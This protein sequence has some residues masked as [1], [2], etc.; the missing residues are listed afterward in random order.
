MAQVEGSW[1]AG[2]RPEAGCSPDGV[3][4]Q[5]RV[6]EK[7]MMRVR[8]QSAEVAGDLASDAALQPT[9]G[10]DGGEGG[11][12][13]PL[14]DL[15][16]LTRTGLDLLSLS[17][18][19]EIIDYAGR[20]LA[21]RLGDCITIV[22]TSTAGGR[23]LSIRGIFGINKRLLVRAVDLVGDR[24]RDRSCPID[25][26]FESVYRDRRLYRHEAGLVDFSR[27]V[28]PKPV[29]RAL[30]QLLGV[31][32]VYTMGLVGEERVLGNIHLLGLKADL[33]ESPETVEVFAHQVA[34][35]L[36]RAAAHK[37]LRESEAR[38]RG[39]FEHA[40]SGF[41]LH[42]VILDDQGRSVDY[43]FREVNAAFEEMTGLKGEEIV[44]RRA[45]EVL[46][47]IEDEIFIDV[48][49]RVALTGEP[50]HLE[51]YVDALDRYQEITAY[52]PAEGQFVTLIS[53]VTETRQRE[54]AERRLAER[55]TA[56]LRA[57]D[58][59]WWEMELPSGEVAFDDMKAAMLGYPPEC[60]ETYHDFVEL[61]HPEDRERAMRAMRDHLEGRTENYEVQYRIETRDGEL[62][63][64][65]DVGG[66][67]SRDEGTGT[68]RVVGIVEDITERRKAQRALAR[69]ER[70]L[71]EIFDA[72]PIAIEIYDGDGRLVEANPACLELFG[73]QRLEDV[74]G[75]DLFS[76]PNL[77][78]DARASLR[79]GAM[80]RYE[81]EFDFGR[82][83]D[84][85]HYATSKQGRMSIDVRI[86]PLRA[87]T[88]DRPEAYLAQAQNVTERKE[89]E[90]E[91]RMSKQRFEL[92]LHGA[93]LGTWDWEV[94]TGAVQFNER[95]AGMMGYRLE[96]LEPNLDT[97]ERLVHP[98]DLVLAWERLQAHLEGEHPLY[99]AE[100]RM[101]HRSGEWRWILDRGKVIERDERGRPLRA[102]GTHLDITERR[103]IERRLREEERMAAL[104]Q[105]AAGV[106]H[107]FR[108][109]L[110]PI[111][112]Y[113]EMALDRA[114]LPAS[115]RPH[116][117]ATL[118]ESRGMADLVQQIL[119]FTSR[120]MI[121]R[122]R[123]D[124]AQLVED[125]ADSLGDD[126]PPE[127]KMAVR[128]TVDTHTI[129]ADAA[130]IR[131]AV[132][133][134]VLNARD[135]MPDGGDLTLEVSRVEVEQGE[136]PPLS[137][138]GGTD[139]NGS[140]GGP[141]VCLAVSD[142]GTGM[143]EE[144][145]AHLFEPFFTT[146]D[147]GEGIGLGLPQ[148]YGIVRQHEGFV[149]VETTV[150]SGTTFRIFLPAYAESATEA[151]HGK[152]EAS[153]SEPPGCV[154]LVAEKSAWRRSV[155]EALTSTGLRVVTAADAQEAG[156][157]C[158]S[159][160][161]STGRSSI[162]LVVLD[163]S[164]LGREDSGL[165]RRLRR[166]HPSMRVI[167][168]FDPDE[169]GPPEDWSEEGAVSLVEKSAAVDELIRAV[170]RALT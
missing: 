26:R 65:R 160:R 100:M 59:A 36:E 162:D 15:R 46:P 32:D 2:M 152:S 167:G 163:V 133:N 166:A 150:G 76:D 102:C 154:L 89:A 38:Y 114:D 83:I 68:T 131:Q 122:E 155:R 60:F 124:L 51:I 48:Y 54:R 9:A 86:T 117:E 23:A 12:K 63:W 112:L 90:R 120:A 92:A 119:D 103:M 113:A 71:K 98:D 52:A 55:V 149:D 42:D 8:D 35:A 3:E 69:N 134:L 45:T 75:F 137:E 97:W 66:I 44:G 39:L 115:L 139:G 43:V 21:E 34:L 84:Q 99:E 143:T 7:E 141:W 11:T 18:E 121:R 129:L 13:E 87:T 10:R 91:L 58:L 126:V 81:T 27:Q 105:M 145:R 20:T 56:G 6:R 73:V 25:E 146:K 33:I 123:V 148:V 144:V 95:W 70:K 31:R 96:E 170:R 151:D 165:L 30:G 64:F 157:V 14:S 85:E 116:M 22:L 107:D 88:G 138:A 47:G 49:G 1:P 169:N 50:A 101:R 94:Q 93:D 82:V 53:D 156:A 77:P 132:R 5:D 41:A 74:L 4:P 78:A 168:V 125:V 67:A 136:H 111:I 109:R 80:V 61:I 128:T 62:K 29:A 159:P 110:N 16:W 57:G 19:R 79:Q 161:W 127:V 72:S 24:I 108:N 158:Q 40:V 17:S 142:T 135:A 153:A 104:G 130:R 147:V 164:R 140:P 106:A 28:L 37:A 118:E